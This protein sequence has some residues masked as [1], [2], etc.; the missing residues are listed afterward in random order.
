MY[1]SKYLQSTFDNTKIC[2]YKYIYIDIINQKSPRSTYTIFCLYTANAPWRSPC[3]V[4]LPLPQFINCTR[5][6]WFPEEVQIE[7][8]GKKHDVPLVTPNWQVEFK[9]SNKK[10]HDIDVTLSARPEKKV[11]LSFCPNS[12]RLCRLCYFIVTFSYVGDTY[13]PSLS[14]VTGALTMT[15]LFIITL[16]DLLWYSLNKKHTSLPVVTLLNQRCWIC[17][18]AIVQPPTEV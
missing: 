6:P 5:C 18:N 7:T 9:I 14:T 8:W 1:M 4:S 3:I 13:S 17:R 10:K 2:V 15:A 12:F 16:K 11:W